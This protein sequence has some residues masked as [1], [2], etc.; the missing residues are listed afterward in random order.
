MNLP[1]KLGLLGAGRIGQV[2]AAAITADVRDA[3]I[4]RVVDVY[5]ASAEA[6]GTRYGISY[7][8]DPQDIFGDD[9]ID[10]VLICS[11]TDTHA[12]FMIRA[13]EAGKHIFCEKPVDHDLG[14]IDEALAAVEKAGVKCMIGF[15]R[16]FDHNFMKVREMINAGRVGDLHVLQITS[17]DPAPPPISYIKVSGGL[18]MDM[19]IHDFD[20]ARFLFG[21]VEEVYALGGAMVDPAIGEAGD[22]DTAIVTLTF[23]N[24]AMGTINN[25][26]QAVY[27]YD[28]RVEVFGSK[29]MVDVKNDYPNTHTF[30]GAD[31]VVSEKPL[32]FFLERYMDAYKNEMKAFVD[33]V[34][35]DTTEP[36]TV[37]DGRESVVLA[38]AALKSL[39]EKRPVKISE[40]ASYPD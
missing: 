21:E 36:A 3:K 15:N 10:A 29:G 27:G 26:R 28:Q 4:T 18:F 17:R 13:A 9:E 39:Q 30:Y 11:S 1:L 35:N 31:G 34:V 8:T 40:I 12:A 7:S 14:R 5:E 22:V 25:S 19:M 20:M 16:R 37:H 6:L 23:K 33:C 2:H 38:M 24:G 32:Y